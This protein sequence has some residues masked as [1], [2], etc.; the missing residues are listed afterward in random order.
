[1]KLTLTFQSSDYHII[2][3]FMFK[4]NNKEEVELRHNIMTQLP[5]HLCGWSCLD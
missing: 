1:M 5:I 3:H 4:I 2:I